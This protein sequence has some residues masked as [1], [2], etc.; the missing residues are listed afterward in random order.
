MLEAPRDAPTEAVVSALSPTSCR[1]VPEERPGLTGEVVYCAMTRRLDLRQGV[2]GGLAV[3]V[4]MVATSGPEDG[5]PGLA[6][7]AAAVG[8]VTLFAHRHNKR[9]PGPGH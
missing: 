7:C 6:A 2:T 5:L 4:V 1:W 9:I 3:S 8:L